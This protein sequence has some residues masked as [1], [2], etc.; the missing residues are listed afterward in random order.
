MGR[1]YTTQV[2]A[3]QRESVMGIKPSP[4]RQGK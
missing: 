1:L 2:E 4:W 3:E